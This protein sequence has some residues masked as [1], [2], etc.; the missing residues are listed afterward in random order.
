[1]KKLY[2]IITLSLLSIGAFAQCT[3]TSGPTIT[4]N[5]LSITATG[6]GNGAVFPVYGYDWG[7][8]TNPGA[9]QTSSHTYA[10]PGTYL[11]CMYYLDGTAPSTCI[12]TSCVSI[13]VTAVGINDPSAAVLNVQ[14]TP[15]PF[16]SQLTIN[17]TMANT[18]SVEVAIY[19]ITGK[20]VAVLKNGMMAAGANVIDWKPAGISAGVYFL[21]VKTSS[22]LLTKKIVYTQN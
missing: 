21:Q 7:D 20:Q 10:A 8:M 16:S 22:A 4:Q 11:V 17:L 5:G 6:N 15:N 9:S 3:I 18:E 1:M 2:S 13:S 12:D 14:A 19:D